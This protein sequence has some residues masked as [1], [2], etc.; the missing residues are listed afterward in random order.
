MP[1]R[2]SARV[3]QVAP[4]SVDRRTVRSLRGREV[5]QLV[6]VAQ[7]VVEHRAGRGRAERHAAVGGG[8]EVAGAL[9]RLA[10]AL[11]VLDHLLAPIYIRVLFGAGPLTPDYLDGLVDRLLA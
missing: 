3:G 1:V 5:G 4:S 8:G 2:I 6:G 9:V 7:R 11:E 10:V